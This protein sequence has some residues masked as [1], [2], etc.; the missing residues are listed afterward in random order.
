M[1]RKP[2]TFLLPDVDTFVRSIPGGDDGILPSSTPPGEATSLP[3]FDLDERRGSSSS[4]NCEFL[5]PM[6]CRD[7]DG[8][9]EQTLSEDVSEAE[10]TLTAPV[11]ELLDLMNSVATKLND[12]EGEVLRLEAL[13]REVAADWK[14]QKEVLLKQ[15]GAY[16][17][18]QARP[19]MDAFQTKQAIQVSVT[20]ATALYSQA[21]A[22]CEEMRAVLQLTHETGASDSHLAELLDLL[23]VAQTKRDAF[24]RLSQERMAEFQSVQDKCVSLKGEIGIRSLERAWPWYEAYTKSKVQSETLAGSIAEVRAGMQRMKEHYR[25]SMAALETISAQVHALRQTHHQS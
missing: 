7:V 25:T 4:D 1:L 5:S 24:E 16:A 3:S 17:I 8:V 21:N 23:V 14:R 12:S 18:E 13:R 11:Q 10:R 9:N 19:L 6:S 15:I 2:S 22:E 20:E